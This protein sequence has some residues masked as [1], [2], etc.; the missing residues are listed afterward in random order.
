MAEV[1]YV[2]RNADHGGWDKKHVWQVSKDTS[3]DY[4]G[5]SS[6]LCKTLKGK[7]V[8]YDWYTRLQ[9]LISPETHP[10]PLETFHHFCMNCHSEWY[11]LVKASTKEQP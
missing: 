10:S 6:P 5:Y 2:V 9:E 8:N 1:V 7:S 4:W 11:K 3:S